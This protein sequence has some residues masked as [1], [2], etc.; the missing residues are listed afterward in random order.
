VSDIGHAL[1]EQRQ[2]RGVA[3]VEHHEADAQQ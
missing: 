1:P 3:Q 2:H